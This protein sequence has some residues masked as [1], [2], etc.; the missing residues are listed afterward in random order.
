[1]K[2]KVKLEKLPPQET[3]RG[4]TKLDRYGEPLCSVRI[5]QSYEQRQE[6]IERMRMLYD[7]YKECPDAW[8]TAKHHVGN[9]PVAY[10]PEDM[11][12]DFAQ[13]IKNW[14]MQK[15]D[16]YKSFVDRHNFLLDLFIEFVG[17]NKIEQMYSLTELLEYNSRIVLVEADETVNKMLKALAENPLF[18]LNVGDL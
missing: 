11:F 7:C 8:G 16:L 6:M 9:D 17:K 14:K 4:K 2:Y 5:K 18:E 12:E 15:N 13:R 1:M 10:S 3:S